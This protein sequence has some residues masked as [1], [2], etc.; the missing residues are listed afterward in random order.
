MTK[1]QSKGTKIGFTVVTYEKASLPMYQPKEKDQSLGCDLCVL[2][3]WFLRGFPGKLCRRKQ[4]I[5]TP[6]VAWFSRGRS[7]RAVARL[8]NHHHEWS[9][10]QAGHRQK[11]AG[12]R[13]C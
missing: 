4:S 12:R 3:V 10:E 7:E 2:L 1:S 8:I 9:T 6:V 11:Q 5:D 13:L